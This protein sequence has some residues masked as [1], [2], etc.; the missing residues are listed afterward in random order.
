[1]GLINLFPIVSIAKRRAL[2]TGGQSPCETTYMWA[3]SG[4]PDSDEIFS[5]EYQIWE[6]TVLPSLF[7]GGSTSVA[8]HD[9]AT[10]LIPHTKFDSNRTDSSAETVWWHLPNKGPTHR[11]PIAMPSNTRPLGMLL[12]PPYQFQCIQHGRFWQDFWTKWRIEESF[13][14][15]DSLEVADLKIS[16]TWQSLILH[17]KFDSNRTSSSVQRRRF[18]VRCQNRGQPWAPLTG[19]KSPW[20]AEFYIHTFSGTPILISVYSAR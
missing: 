13:V 5:K 19:G 1:M 9:K 7:E 8:Q 3:C 20:R 18:I 11:G 14:P 10:F 4:S 12:K 15:P 16:T 6:S 2:L 17:T